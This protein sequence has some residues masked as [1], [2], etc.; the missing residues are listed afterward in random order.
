MTGKLKYVRG[1]ENIFVDLGFDK[2][3]AENLKLRFELLMKID[4]F[5]RRSGTPPYAYIRARQVARGSAR[6]GRD[7]QGRPRAQSARRVLF[8]GEHPGAP[9]VA[10]LPG[11][12]ARDGG[13]HRRSRGARQHAPQALRGPAR[14]L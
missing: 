12:A 11:R 9:G 6:L 3:E 10:Q 8:A 4:D 5:Y 7:R 1:S 2:A 13:A 14:P